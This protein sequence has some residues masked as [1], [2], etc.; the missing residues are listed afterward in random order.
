MNKNILLESVKEF[1][2][3]K[4]NVSALSNTSIELFPKGPT[5]PEV[6]ESCLI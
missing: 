2:I 4:I 1:V 6:H 3:F 5:N